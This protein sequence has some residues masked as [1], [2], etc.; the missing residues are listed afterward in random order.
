MID[1]LREIVLPKFDRVRRSGAG[2]MV[3]CPVHE[4]REASLAVGPG[5]DHPVVFHCHAGCQPDDIL[6]ALGLTWADLSKSREHTER[7]QDNADTWTPA[8]PAV[9]IYDYRDEHGELLFQV[10]RTANK[11]FRQRRPDA[12]AKSG[13]SWKLDGVR[14]V[15]YRL[16]KVLEAVQDGREIYLCEGEKDVHTLE[17]HGLVA[18]CNPGGA[19]KWRDDYT[20]SLRGAAVVTIIADRDE[21]G[22][23]HARAVK[24]ALV[25]HVGA[26]YIVEAAAGKDATDHVAAGHSLAE[27]ETTFSSETQA[28][29]ELA[30]DLWE[31]I[32]G[33]EPA[34][35]WI[36]P[37]ILER[38]D[39]VIITG[40]E[41]LGKSML[42]RQLAV[43]IAAGM[44]PFYLSRHDECR[45][46]RVLF[47]DC[48]NSERQSR[49]KFRPLADASVKYRHPVPE[50]ALRLIHRP[51]GIDLT[52]DEW[53]AWLLERVNAHRPDV[54]FIGPFYRLHNANLNDELPARKVAAVLDKARNAVGCALVTEAHAGHGEHGVKRSVRPAGSSLMLRWPEFGFGLREADNS[55]AIGGRP[56]YVEV[57]HWRG[58]RDDR[59]WPGYLEMGS[60]NEWPW[61]WALGVPPRKEA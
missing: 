33:T 61:K 25:E 38:S 50:G 54:L 26:V 16:P 48:E 30:P 57:R 59:N 49:R 29:P 51:E 46:R 34:Y 28:K 15:L 8:G 52:K 24:N 41:G 56:Q 31:F 37:D 22:R 4:D 17:R 18:T 42:L 11:D 35:D 55:P 45:P 21:P 32:A 58:G 60:P 6:H 3:Q 9:A 53:A 12:T 13:W 7:T 23:A 19:G 20:D 5:R 47:I 39:R 44:H 40:F 27:L 36:V 1:A 2:Y 10:C 14:R 43:M